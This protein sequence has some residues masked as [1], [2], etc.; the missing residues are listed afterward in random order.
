MGDVRVHAHIGRGRGRGKGWYGVY[1][2]D[3]ITSDAEDHVVLGGENPNM[4]C[5][6]TPTQT[7]GLSDDGITV[8]D[9]F[10]Y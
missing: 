7:N 2:F 5:I 10:F 1:P 4:S 6:G 3:N 8:E 9:L